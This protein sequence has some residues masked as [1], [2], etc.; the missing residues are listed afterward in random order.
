[1]KNFLLGVVTGVVVVIVGGILYLWLGFTE[2]RVDVAPSSFENRFMNAAVH[3]SVRRHAPEMPNPIAPTDENLI[4][5]GKLFMENCGGC[6]GSFHN[7]EDDSDSLFPRIP[8]LHKVGT[9]YTEAQ[10][11]W[12]AKHGIRHTGMFANGKWRSDKDLWSM[13]AYVKRILNLTATVQ[14][15]LEPKK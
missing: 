3:A 5:G 1:M 9:E 13:A 14:T 8:Q 6:H 4:A 11:F 2:T 10:I 7:P 12:I 15:A